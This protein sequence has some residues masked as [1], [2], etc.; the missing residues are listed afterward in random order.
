MEAKYKFNIK[1]K[2]NCLT[3]FKTTYEQS[4]VYFDNLRELESFQQIV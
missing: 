3:K 2:E 1:A 4:F